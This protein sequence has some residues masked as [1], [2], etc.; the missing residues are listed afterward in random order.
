M[1][2][3][4]TKKDR[5]IANLEA[6]VKNRDILIKNVTETNETLRLA[7][8]DMSDENR[9]LRN[10]IENLE[11]DLESVRAQ[12]FEYA[13]KTRKTTRRK[14]EAPTATKQ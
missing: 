10:I 5:K 14:K 12:S 4:F 3:I 11:K 2:G 6:K 7:I 8:N 1:F 13:N 9:T